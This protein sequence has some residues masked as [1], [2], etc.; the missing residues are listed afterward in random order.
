MVY[1]LFFF[2]ALLV[3][4]LLA[5]VLTGSAMTGRLSTEGPARIAA[6][7]KRRNRLILLVVFALLAV[8]ALAELLV[9][10]LHTG[11]VDLQYSMGQAIGYYEGA[12][13]GISWLFYL[14]LLFGTLVGLLVG[15]LVS[16][17]RFAIARGLGVGDAV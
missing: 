12:N 3:F 6:A 11:L 14:S 5:F 13:G 2:L 16:V 8:L 4:G 9:Y 17:R 7:L 15:T 1:A 10:D